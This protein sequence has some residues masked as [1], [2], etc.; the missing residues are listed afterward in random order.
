MPELADRLLCSDGLTSHLPDQRIRGRL[1][2][3][4]WARQ[5]ITVVVR[6]AVA[7]EEDSA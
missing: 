1:R 5:A 2:S 6:R 3:M 7:K 4:T